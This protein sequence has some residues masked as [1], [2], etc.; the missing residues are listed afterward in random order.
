[1][2]SKLYGLLKWSND[3]PI[4][5]TLL[6]LFLFAA[7]PFAISESKFADDPRAWAFGT[8]IILVVGGTW[9]IAL[10][11]YS[12]G[13]VASVLILAIIMLPIRPAR[14]AMV[15]VGVVVICVGGYCL[16]KVVKVCQKKFPPKDTNAPPAEFSAAGEDEYGGAVEYSSIGSCFIPLSLNSN[17]Y[18]NLLI[19]P[20]TFTLNIMVEPIGASVSMSVNND[21]GTTQTWDQFQAEMA[22]HGLFLTGHPSY[23]PQYEL[24]GVPCDPSMVPLEFDPFTGRVTHHTAGEMRRVVVERSPNLVEWAP[25]LVTD[26]GVGSGFKVI[27]TTREGQC[28]YRVSVSSP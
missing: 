18:E 23:P 5:S 28:F 27:D 3:H 20:T 4:L 21:E 1:M 13:F 16:Y 15:G 12:K 26:T 7:I 24:G 22:T 11:R 17:P 8:G 14:S 6:A 10:W 25:L 2:K 19:N 9:C